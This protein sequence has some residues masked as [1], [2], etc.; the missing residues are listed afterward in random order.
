MK[1]LT[2]LYTFLIV[3]LHSSSAATNYNVLS[4]GA[5][6]DGVTDSTQAFLNAWAAACGS[7]ESTTIYVP[8]GT[9]LLG[10]SVA[11]KGDCKSSDIKILIDGTLVAPLDYNVLGEADNWLSFEGVDNVSIVGG[12]VNANGSALWACKAASYNCPTGA[13][14]SQNYFV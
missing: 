13:T 7:T 2:F 5:K 4:F 10:S 3:C 11:F 8:K 9:Y 14:V 12:T 6:G 1:F